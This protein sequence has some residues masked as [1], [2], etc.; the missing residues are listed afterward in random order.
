MHNPI[1]M[2]DDEQDFLDSARR[3]LLGAGFRNVKLE[4]NPIDAAAAV[5]N[6]AKFDVA[7]LDITM[8][9]MDGL[10]LLE[11]IKN[12][13]PDTECIMV[14]AVNEAKVAVECLKKG[15][16]DYLTKPLSRD[17]MV[18]AIR[19]ALERKRLL[20]V[21]AVVK[22]EVPPQISPGKIS[23]VM[24]ASS[25]KMLRLLKEA[26]LYASITVPLLITGQPGTGKETMARHIHE[27]GSRKDGPFVV[28][29]LENLKDDQYLDALFGSEKGNGHIDQARRG[30]LFLGEISYL[31]SNMQVMLLK[32]MQENSF[33]RPGT[34]EKCPLDTRLIISTRLDPEALVVKGELRKDLYY[35]IKGS[36]LILPPL[37]ERKGDV[38]LLIEHYLGK[39]S[40][41][42][43]VAISPEAM[44]TLC[45]Y[46]FPG[47]I[48]E[49]E[50]IVKEMLEHTSG[51]V[52]TRESLPESVK[53]TIQV[54]SIMNR[55]MNLLKSEQCAA[56]D[57]VYIAGSVQEQTDLIE[58]LAAE[59]KKMDA[60]NN[61]NLSIS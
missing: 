42:R 26:E 44:S 4:S 58:R 6:G 11:R 41:E 33:V 19:R 3:G 45:D 53:K 60:R 25:E 54:S 48:S 23:H 15:A 57:D 5:E 32:A 35:F 52:V 16:Y 59:I 22:S 12:A 38:P 55:F 14:S 18:A 1:L 47:N 27:S 50:S 17:E 20:D 13:S 46:D 29:D 10:Q 2:V 39:Y 43:D 61:R 40:G 36:K 49:L 28:A 34:N 30:T 21:I 37:R 51:N 24:I 56:Y 8:P 31:P 9:G 7:L